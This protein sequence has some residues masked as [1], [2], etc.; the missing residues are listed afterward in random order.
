MLSSSVETQVRGDENVR[1]SQLAQYRSQRLPREIDHPK[2]KAHHVRNNYVGDIEVMAERPGK[3]KKS[4]KFGKLEEYGGEEEVAGDADPETEAEEAAA[5]DDEE[6]EE[7]MPNVDFGLVDVSS[8]GMI[9]ACPVENGVINSRWGAVAA[10]PLITGLAAGLE[11]QQVQARE[12]LA[13]SRSGQYRA[14]QQG[15]N[16]VDN[17]FAATL[18][19]DLGEVA[20]LQGPISPGSPQVGAP[21]A[22]NSSAIPRWFF[23]SQRERLEMTDAEI[24]GGLDGLILADGISEW[25]GQAP[26]LRLSQVLD[27]YYSHVSFLVRLLFFH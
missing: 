14:R 10:G 26:G 22:W 11:P 21:G 27:M 1:C 9:S 25:R 5:A 2:R 16:I 20:L 15:P 7:L 24:R 23:I 4:P 17:K 19:G 13:H 8:S 3:F 12:L 6:G 18:A